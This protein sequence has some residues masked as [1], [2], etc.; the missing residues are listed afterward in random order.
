LWRIMD[1]RYYK[2]DVERVVEELREIPERYVFL[3]DDEP[4]VN[5]Q[6]MAEMAEGIAEAGIEKEYF[7]Y[8]RIDSLLRDID[9]MKQWRDIGLRRLF[10]G[11]ETIFDHELKDYNKRQQHKDIVRAIETAKELDIH[12][13][14]NFIIHPSYTEH[15]F[16]QVIQFIRTHQIEY[17]SFT[18]WTPIPGTGQTYEDVLLRQAN[19]RPQWE[20]FDLQHPVI[21]TRLPRAEFQQQYDQLHQTFSSNYFDWRSPLMMADFARRQAILRAIAAKVLGGSSTAAPLPGC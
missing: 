2:R 19:G 16:Q 20:F 14:C 13:L 15:E 18:I 1:G 3:V 12:L 5:P 4:F 9:L 7:S 8:C 11:V 17:P 6:R 21:E 10:L